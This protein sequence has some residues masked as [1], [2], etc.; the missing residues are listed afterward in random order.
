MMELCK[1]IEHEPIDSTSYFFDK[2]EIFLFSFYFF[3]KKDRATKTDDFC[4]TTKGYV[5]NFYHK[6]VLVEEMISQKYTCSFFKTIIKSMEDSTFFF[7]E[8]MPLIALWCYKHMKIEEEEINQ[9]LRCFLLPDYELYKHAYIKSET[10]K[11]T[12]AN[13]SYFFKHFYSIRYN[14]LILRYLLKKPKHITFTYIIKA[15]KKNYI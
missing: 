5:F 11:L 6:N 9:D 3:K 15:I 10:L 8:N 1:I 4:F 14:V 7:N 2:K 12:I 13:V